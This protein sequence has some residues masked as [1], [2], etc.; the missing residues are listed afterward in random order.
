MNDALILSTAGDALSRPAGA[1]H[2]LRDKALKGRNKP[3]PH[4][5]AAPLPSSKVE[6]KAVSV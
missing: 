2:L 5:R 3:C 6:R 1:W 4:N